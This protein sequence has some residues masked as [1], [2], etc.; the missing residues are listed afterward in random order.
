MI[1]RPLAKGLYTVATRL[2]GENVDRNLELLKQSQWLSRQELRDLQWS[3]LLSLIDHAIA[4]SPYYGRLF[5][6]HGLSRQSIISPDDLQRIP[7]LTKEALRKEYDAIRVT[8]GHHKYSMAKTSG[9]TGL[10]LKFF[11]D[12]RASGNGR[13]AMYRG[14]TWYGADIGD[15]EAR[16]WGVHLRLKDRWV[17]HAGDYLLNRFRARSLDLTDHVLNEFFVRMKRLKPVYLMGYSSMVYQFAKY[18]TREKMDGSQLALRF[19]KV[20][21]ETL[22]D[23]QRQLIEEVFQCPVASE[24]GAAEVG[25]VSFECPEHGHHIASENVYVEEMA[26]P[27]GLASELVI[28]DLNNLLSPIIRYRI[29]DLGRLSSGTCPCGRG[30]PLLED[31]QGRVSDIVYRADGQPAHSLLFYYILKEL[32][33]RDG[34]IAQYRFIQEAKG[35]LRIEL[36]RSE[37]YSAATLDL[38][39]SLLIEQLGPGMA[40]DFRFVDRIAREP[41]GKLRDF[42]SRIS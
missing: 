4:N 8:N 11:K 12:R 41:S 7:L 22:P 20:T 17:M 19:V 18:L 32:T 24:Y 16:L 39:T 27:T 37:R 2:R 40:L 30:L 10:S 34:G 6:E 23:F 28:T 5:A 15:R 31:I 29:G 14:H 35:K 25:I 13:A 26:S 38:L 36:V 42:I 33:A 21:S 1:S 9:S 3:R